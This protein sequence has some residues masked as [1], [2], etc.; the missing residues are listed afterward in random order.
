MF[1]SGSYV[2]LVT[3]WTRD[4]SAVDYG[5]LRE[6]VEWHVASGSDGVVPAG[7]TGESATLDHKEQ[8]R[9]V[10]ETV[11]I[12]AGRCK[13]LAGAG[14]N[15]TSEAVSLA[16]HAKAAGADAILVITPYYNRPTPEG[17]YRHFGTV[18]ENCDLPMM[19]YNVP[20][21][22]GIN[23]QPETVARI[24]A[25]YPSVKGV[26]ESSGAVD[27][28]SRI[29]ALAGGGVDVMSGD[30][31]LAVPIMS[32]GGTGVV[33]VGA[34]LAPAL[35]KRMTAAALSGDYAA[36]RELH[37]RLLPLM[38]AC[39]VETNPAPTKAALRIMGRMDG[40]MRLPMVD[41]RP[42]SETVVKDA[43]RKLGL[44]D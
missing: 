9:L 7:T 33:S 6:L 41:I 44:V 40:R 28:S 8:E 34:N 17:L 25:A 36:A 24:A 35:V 38:R 15:S 29:V 4:L 26:K 3:P 22:T 12:A 13:V 1:F 10:T 20:A 21:R 5:A 18:A 16:R 39:F 42:E 31:S 11:K 2:A 43:L 32:I 23:M 30:D 19:V 27:Q 14:S 37:Y